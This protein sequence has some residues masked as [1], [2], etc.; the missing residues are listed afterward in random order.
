M[1]IYWWK[2]KHEVDTILTYAMFWRENL[3]GGCTM[4]YQQ[5]KK[6]D[7]NKQA[8]CIALWFRMEKDTCEESAQNGVNNVLPQS[9]NCGSQ[10]KSEY[11]RNWQ[12]TRERVRT[13]KKKSRHAGSN[14][15]I[16]CERHNRIIETYRRQETHTWIRFIFVKILHESKLSERASHTCKRLIDVDNA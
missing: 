14:N 9:K 16:K 6:G 10:L 7:W 8:F 11:E 4:N 3:P 13:E 5:G 15:G 2:K 12:R 1:K